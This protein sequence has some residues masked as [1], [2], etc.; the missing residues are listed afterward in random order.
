MMGLS[1]EEMSELR[2]MEARSRMELTERQALQNSLA[3]IQGILMTLNR[4]LCRAITLG[5]LMGLLFFALL[6][7]MAVRLTWSS[8][9]TPSTSTAFKSPKQEEPSD[10]FS[11]NTFR[12]ADGSIFRLKPQPSS[13]VEDWQRCVA[14][15][16]MS[17]TPNSSS[18]TRELQSICG[19]MIEKLK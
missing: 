11:S 4:S 14:A 6:A 1:R 2:T 18:T 16:L 5:T 19:T 10:F 9:T 17:A 3:A 13:R 8:P 7:G 15:V 12:T